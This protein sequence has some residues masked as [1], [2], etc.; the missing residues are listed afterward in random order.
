ML[1]VAATPVS[2][3]VLDTRRA[4]V[5]PQSRRGC[6]AGSSTNIARSSD[7][8]PEAASPRVP[9]T[10]PFYI[11]NYYALRI[12]TGHCRARRILGDS[13]SPRISIRVRL[14]CLVSEAAANA[15]ELRPRSR[16][17]L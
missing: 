2:L 10:E 4:R 17:S 14:S 5:L 11:I 7:F 9:F 3:A 15:V 8:R 12:Q 16:L 1:S 13:E 6:I